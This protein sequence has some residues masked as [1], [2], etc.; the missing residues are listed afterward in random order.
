MVFA[1][2][3]FCA[4]FAKRFPVGYN[5]PLVWPSHPGHENA[6]HIWLN[7]QELVAE[8]NCATM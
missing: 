6:C 3:L 1:R 8:P 5:G 7:M 2:L 4:L